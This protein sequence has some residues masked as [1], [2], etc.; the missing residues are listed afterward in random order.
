MAQICDS[1]IAGRLPQYHLPA[2]PGNF[3]ESY[4]STICR[5]YGAGGAGADPPATA[6]SPA[7]QAR[8]LRTGKARRSGA[9]AGRLTQIKKM[10]DERTFKIIGAGMEACPPLQAQAR[11][12]GAKGTWLWIPL[13]KL[14]APCFWLDLC[15]CYT[16]YRNIS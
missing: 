1:A 12:A 15:S 13:K 5:T 14:P 3:T 4:P 6:S 11:W 16:Y 9:R 8:A 10:S 2:C 7:S